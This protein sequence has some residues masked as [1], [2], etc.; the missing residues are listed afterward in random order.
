MASLQTNII[1][2]ALD[3]TAKTAQHSMTHIENVYMLS[4]HDVLDANKIAEILTRGHSRVPVF[5]WAGGG[6]QAMLHKSWSF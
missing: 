5:R 1:R 2:G 4:T 3:L 6:G